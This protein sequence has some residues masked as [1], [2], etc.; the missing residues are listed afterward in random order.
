MTLR[1]ILNTF[2]LTGRI[3]TRLTLTQ[4]RSRY[5]CF[6][7]AYRDGAQMGEGLGEAKISLGVE[8]EQQ[9]R[10]RIKIGF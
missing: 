9:P 10:W 2:I 5:R 1:F 6:A 4:W 8:S 3:N 7:P